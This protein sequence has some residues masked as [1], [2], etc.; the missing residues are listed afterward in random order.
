M[1]IL[2][3]KNLEKS[4]TN[5]VLK[6]KVLKGVNIEIKEGEFV[7]IMGKSGSGKSTLLNILSSLDMPDNGEIYFEGREITHLGEEEA[8]KL[9]RESFGFVFQLP[10]MVRNL[11]ILDNILLPS[12][13]YKKNKNDLMDKAK[14]LM[15]KIGI[16]HIEDNRI[17]QVSG[18]QLQRAGICRALINN[19]KILFAD[20]PTGALDSKT[21]QEVLELFSIFHAEGKSIL[22][23]THDVQV[24]SKADRV[25]FMKDGLLVG[26]IKLGDNCKEGVIQIQEMLNAI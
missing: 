9:R 4:Y 22:M 20:E 6:T 16:E 19:P 13:N 17:S 11:S 10:K 24:A 25:L 8:A 21:G 12:I 15:K 1:I 18:G 23:V 3:G 7:S 5:G 2:K 14:Q 26:E